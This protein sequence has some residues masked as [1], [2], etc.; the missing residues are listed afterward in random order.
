[1]TN[2]ILTRTINEQAFKQ[3]QLSGIDST[4][5]KLF[6]ARSVHN[7]NELQY[8]LNQLLHYKDLKNIHQAAQR[9]YEALIKKQR[10]L[11]IADYDAD[12]ATACAVG[13]LGLKQMGAIVDFL[14][15]NRFE[16]G[17]GLTPTLVD[18]AAQ[19]KTE[20]IVTVDNG[21]ASIEGVAHAQS[22]GIDVLITD[23]HLPADTLPSCII[24]NPNQPDCPFPSKS[25]AG[26]GVI[27]YLLIALRVLLREKN[28]FHTAMLPEP[29]LINL[30]DLVAVGTV[31]DV[32]S[33]D[34]NNRILVTQ[35][36]KRI[37]NGKMR[38]GLTALFHI[39]KRNWQQ[40]Q[41]FDLGYAIAPRINAAGRLDDISIG[42]ACLITDDE[43]EALQLA[44][45]LDSLN[46]ERRKIEHTMLDTA[47]SHI[48]TNHPA[49]TQWSFSLHHPEW[50]QGVIGILAGRIKDRFYR[51]T[52]IFAT[53]EKGI[54]RGS[55]RSIPQ[56]HLRDALDLI[57]KRYP[58]LII[59][60]GGH[61]MAA[62]L[63]IEEE[64]FRDFT[65]AF[66]N[67]VHELLTPE[68]ITKSFMT[69]GSLPDEQRTLEYAQYLGQQVWGQNFPAPS[70]TDI[71]NV[72]WQKPVGTKHLKAGLEKSGTIYEGMFFNCTEKLPNQIKT[73]Y[74][75]IAN[76][77][78]Q[79]YELQLYID[80]WQP[81][82]PTP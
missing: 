7:I 9:L 6:A 34:Q 55:G 43:Q 28:Y 76:E 48:N 36:I 12:G 27:Y 64:N 81:Y 78:R 33:L 62:G 31:A 21:I 14:V 5:A 56:L 58:K 74:R 79:Q 49:E 38:P 61:A 80:Y 60:F 19:Q 8:N 51:P 52:I 30:L 66:E 29:N 32:V 24:V 44:Q 15:P 22:L 11:I 25:L 82:Y 37:Q 45:Q 41:A 47:L 35:G 71:F 42:I 68:D 18:L 54:L 3:L 39:A 75:P 73:V 13:I 70:F 65:I 1:M 17:Y 59:K 26:V 46:R 57:S 40:A 67:I 69:D 16:H 50:H 20:L 63:S 23:H 4:S 2:P 77:W 53:A 72:A 10:I